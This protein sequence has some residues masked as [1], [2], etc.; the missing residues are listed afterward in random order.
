MLNSLGPVLSLDPPDFDLNAQ[1]EDL[2]Y[3]S[4]GGPKISERHK[5]WDLL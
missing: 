5:M 2:D 4:S 3:E 1:P